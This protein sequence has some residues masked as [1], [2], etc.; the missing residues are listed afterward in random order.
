MIRNAR[1]FSWF[2][3]ISM[4]MLLR[5]QHFFLIWL[6][7]CQQTRKIW[8]K[9]LYNFLYVRFSPEVV[10]VRTK[11]YHLNCSCKFLSFS[12]YYVS[13]HKIAEISRLL[14]IFEP[15]VYRMKHYDC[16][17][18]NFFC[19]LNLW[20]YLFIFWFYEYILESPTIYTKK[21]VSRLFFMVNKR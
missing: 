21:R 11:R 1:L 16:I 4:P 18:H 2:K 7:S 12:S 15:F 8:K 6:F 17:N 14:T 20:F 13:L 3:S 9:I 19:V 10:L 5:D